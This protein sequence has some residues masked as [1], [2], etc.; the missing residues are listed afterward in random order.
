MFYG[1]TLIMIEDLSK[2]SKDTMNES[3]FNKKWN[4]II[5]YYIKKQLMKA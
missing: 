4:L 2:N 1:F 5:I 3:E